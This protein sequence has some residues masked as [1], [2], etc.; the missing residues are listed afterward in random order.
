MAE[1]RLGNRTITAYRWRSFL[2]HGVL[3]CAGSDFPVESHNPL[4]GIDA[5]CRRKPPGSDHPWHPTE[6][7]SQLEAIEAYT[8]NAHRAADT[9]DRR[10]YLSIDMDADMTILDRNIE[11]CPPEEIIETRTLATVVGGTLYEHV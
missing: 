10:G 2:Q 4:L 11:T 3:L 5:F 6:C 1:R 8:I 9:N 7:L